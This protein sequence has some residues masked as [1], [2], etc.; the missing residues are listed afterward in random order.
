VGLIDV[1]AERLRSVIACL[2]DV[3]SSGRKVALSD[4]PG[5]NLH[6]GLQVEAF[7]GRDDTGLVKTAERAFV[8]QRSEEGWTDI[9][10]KLKALGMGAGQQYLD[11]PRDDAQSDGQLWRV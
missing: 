8:W 10:E 4:C 11:G 1:D 9:V 3:I 2:R 5:A 7:P 6:L